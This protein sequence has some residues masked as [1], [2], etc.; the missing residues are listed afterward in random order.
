[1][2]GTGARAASASTSASRVRSCNSPSATGPGKM[3]SAAAGWANMSVSSVS[4]ARS[5][6]IGCRGA[7]SATARENAPTAAM[8]RIASAVGTIQRPESKSGTTLREAVIVA[9]AAAM[10]AAG[11]MRSIAGVIAAP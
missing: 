5:C 4:S 6:R 10:V 3:P 7:G 1:M 8:R 2:V 11:R 9:M